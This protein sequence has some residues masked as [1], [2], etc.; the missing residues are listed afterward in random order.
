V[1]IKPDFN[2]QLQQDGWRIDLTVEG[3]RHRPWFATKR[4]AEDAIAQLTLQKRA[5]RMGLPLP[6]AKTVVTLE[7]LLAARK[8]ELAREQRASAENN[9]QTCIEFAVTL[10]AGMELAAIQP[11]HLADYVE[12]M[13]A[14]ELSG[15]TINLRLSRLNSLFHSA[16]RHF[17]DYEWKPP[18]I[19]FV[20]ASPRRERVLTAEEL[21]KLYGVL[22]APEKLPREYWQVFQTRQ[23][24]GADLF[25]LL[26]LTGARQ[27][28]IA[29]LQWSAVSFPFN[30][31]TLEATKTNDRR[32]LPMTPL[33]R[34]ILERR[35]RSHPQQPIPSHLESS[36]FKFFERIGARAG[37]PYG[38]DVPQGWT[39]HTL[40]HTAISVMLRG[41]ADLLSV[42]HV[43]GHANAESI[44]GTTL[45]YA[46]ASQQSMLNALMILENFWLKECQQVVSNS[47]EKPTAPR[48]T[49]NLPSQ[50][51][52]A[53]L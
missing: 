41:G 33:L 37:V 4:E 34:S 32:T 27:G 1:K 40:R 35:K 28:E 17:P 30:T 9:L 53:G 14:R 26:L 22:S 23:S 52:A 5:R 24:Y 13:Q 21:R 3:K 10:P 12:A 43:V 47:L 18:H 50:A 25:L 49:A 16:A 39:L 19:P 42:Q 36:R 29:N 20:K 31:F 6:K 8:R 7:Q 38:Q 2:E 51:L 44:F 45:V 48:L 15:N 46:H 11:D